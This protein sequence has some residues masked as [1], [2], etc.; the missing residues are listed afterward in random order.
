L[1][2]ILTGWLLLKRGLAIW[3]DVSG[4]RIIM[5]V[6]GKR[7]LNNIPA[8]LRVYRAARRSMNVAIS[9]EVRDGGKK[10]VDANKLDEE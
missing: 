4:N 8:G 10:D 3:V 9:G 6:G 2:E 7:D 5:V 1:W